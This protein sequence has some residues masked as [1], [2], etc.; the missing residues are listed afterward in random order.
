MLQPSPAR[1]SLRPPSSP[2]RA[3]SWLLRLRDG[4]SAPPSVCQ[5]G[6][7]HSKGARCQPA[8][9][10]CQHP[11]ASSKCSR[12]LGSLSLR[13]PRS[14]DVF[15][16]RVHHIMSRVRFSLLS[17]RPALLIKRFIFS[18]KIQDLEHFP[19]VMCQRMFTIVTNYGGGASVVFSTMK[20]VAFETAAKLPRM[21]DPG[22]DSSV[23]LG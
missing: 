6:F 4:C 11:R 7:A 20:L 1:A 16:N 8:I 3:N 15:L 23:N 22:N 13:A 19:A 2:R 17:S 9:S 5:L 21:E 12:T 14:K 10:D 18:L